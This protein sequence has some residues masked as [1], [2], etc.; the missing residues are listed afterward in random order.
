MS[1]MCEE[2]LDLIAARCESLKN[3]NDSLQKDVK[4]YRDARDV[5][6]RSC[7]KKEATITEFMSRVNELKTEN[8]DLRVDMRILLRDG[9]SGQS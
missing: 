4:W 9:R 5:A 3:I 8:L 1:R 2:E 6:V 7:T